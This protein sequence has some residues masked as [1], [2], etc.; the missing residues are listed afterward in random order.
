MEHSCEAYWTKAEGLARDAICT[1]G[2]GAK[3]LTDAAKRQLEIADLRAGVNVG[4]RELGELLYATHTGTPTDSEL[5]LEKMR[6]IDEL[7][8]R[9]RELEGEPIIHL[10]CPRCGHEVQPE[11][12]YCR[13]C[14]DFSRLFPKEER[15][16][17][18]VRQKAANGERVLIYTKS[19]ND[20]YVSLLR[21]IPNQ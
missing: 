9:L 15:V 2:L 16:L 12:V 17:E 8:A 21:R 20:G 7:K 14:G 3:R 5:L 10:I 4:L 18:L 19:C 6:E 1:M 11:D 13:D